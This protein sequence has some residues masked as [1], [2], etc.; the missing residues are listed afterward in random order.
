MA[1]DPET[2]DPALDI[3]LGNRP[4]LNVFDRNCLWPAREAVDHCE[5]ILA[6]SGLRER[7]DEVDVDMVESP[8]RGHKSLEWGFHVG[9]DFR[10]LAAQTG[11]RPQRNLFVKAVPH[12]FGCY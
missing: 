4:G 12:E 2:R 11:L 6:A 9:L 1:W 8:D 10:P 5:E 7:P 3:C